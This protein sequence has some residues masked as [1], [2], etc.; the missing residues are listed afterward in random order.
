M[1]VTISRTAWTDDDGSGTTGTVINNAVKTELYNQIDTALALVPGLALANNFTAKQYLND[2][3][4]ANNT[5]GWTL[6]Q[7]TNDDEILSLKSSDVAHGIT[8]R[9]ETDTYGR[10]AKSFAQGGVDLFGLM[11][12]GAGAA[13]HAV[14][15]VGVTADAASTTKSTVGFGQIIFDGRIKSGTTEASCG[16]NSN[17]V[18]VSDIGTTRFILDADGDSHQDVGTAWTNFD[19]HDDIALLDALAI[20]VSREDDPWKARIRASFADALDRLLPRAAM[21]AMKLVQFNPDGHHF[22]N[23]SKLTM[24]HTGA[25]RQLGTRQ[26]QLA[27]RVAALERRLLEGDA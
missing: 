9:T 6:N 15:L 13:G 17:L 10:I 14:R 23:M 18:S 1:P 16:A 12:T 3:S 26:A 25:L 7:G 5:L 4:N 20:E 27:T 8:T 22:V 19:D 24:L 2:T 21:Q 11:A